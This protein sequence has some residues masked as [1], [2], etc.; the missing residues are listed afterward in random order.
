MILRNASNGRLLKDEKL[1]AQ[2]FD[3]LK[4]WII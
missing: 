1:I 2:L 4:Q 3:I